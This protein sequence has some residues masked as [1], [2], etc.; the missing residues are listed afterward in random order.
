MPNP[1]LTI[2]PFHTADEA[3]VVALW[4][5]CGLTRPWNDPHKDIAR[6]LGVQR[7]WFLVGTV[8]ADQTAHGLAAPPSS[9]DAIH[10]G[11]ARAKA[12]PPQLIASVMAGYDGHRGW[13][14]Y[15]AVH[16]AHQRQ[17]HA[18]RLMAQVETLLTAAGCPKLSLQVRQ[19]N[20]AALA[21]YETLGYGVD[22]VVSMGKRLIPD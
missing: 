3:D 17:G 22:P 12:S 21:F 20:D 14:N 2:R 6:K 5:A 13:V 10:A 4:Q 7:E 16:P 18:A 19:G 1:S 9:T 11:E 8:P 15:L